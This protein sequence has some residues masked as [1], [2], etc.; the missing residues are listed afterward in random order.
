MAIANPEAA[1]SGEDCGG[2]DDSGVSEDKV[3]TLTYTEYNTEHLAD[4]VMVMKFMFD[5]HHN[6]LHSLITMF[7]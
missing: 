2:E 3:I 7:V 6:H 1:V 5:A 4:S